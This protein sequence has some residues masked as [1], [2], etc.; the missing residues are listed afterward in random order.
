MA[1]E[2]TYHVVDKGAMSLGKVSLTLMSGQRRDFFYDCVFDSAS[3]QNEVYD[4]IAKPVVDNVLNGFNGTI[5]AYGQ[6]G[7]GSRILSCLAFR[8][9]V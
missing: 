4:S 6:T 8:L 1:S 7:T 2:S 3:T 5:M 9:F